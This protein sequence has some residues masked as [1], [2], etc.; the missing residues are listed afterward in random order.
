MHGLLPTLSD[1]CD[2]QI[3]EV[4]EHKQECM[5]LK[6]VNK[7]SDRSESEVLPI[8]TQVMVQKEDTGPWTHGTIIHHN[9]AEHNKRSYRIKLPLTGHVVT[10][11]TKHIRKTVIKPWM[12]KCI[13]KLK[14]TD[15]D[16]GQDKTYNHIAGKI[17]PD[18]KVTSTPPQTPESPQVDLTPKS[19]T[20]T[21][22]YVEPKYAQ[23]KVVKT[24][25][26]RLVK[27]L[28]I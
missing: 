13:E 18:K 8:G 27:P 10:R 2:D 6:H 11:N 3:C 7:L 24:R 15:N 25:S 28:I 16:N 12:Y 14:Q 21:V 22:Q 19:V 20:P 5:K 1:I 9:K 17:L 4:L 23:P 26:G